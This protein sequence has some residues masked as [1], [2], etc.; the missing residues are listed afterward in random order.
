[1]DSDYTLYARARLASTGLAWLALIVLAAGVGSIVWLELEFSDLDGAAGGQIPTSAYVQ[2]ALG[3][4]LAVFLASG[5]L[6]A[7]AL[8]IR[9]GADYADAHLVAMDAINQGESA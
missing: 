9:V 8:G 4:G 2:L 5:V 1:M 7:T 6:V 3:Q